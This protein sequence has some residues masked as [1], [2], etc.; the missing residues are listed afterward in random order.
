MK[1]IIFRTLIS[2]FFII[3]ASVIYLSTIGIKTNKLNDQISN[4]IKNINENLDVELKDISILIDPFRF[5]INLKSLGVNLNYKNKFIEL[6]SIQSE[7]SI[8][9]VFKNQFILTDLDISTKSVEIKKMISFLRAITNNPKLY[10][11]EKFVKRGFLIAD[12]SL[13]FDNNGN[14]KKNY[15]IKGFVKEGKINFLKRY[16]FSQIDFTFEFFK[17]EL[18]LDD[19]KLSLND[20]KFFLSGVKVTKDTNKFLFSGNLDNKLIKID[21]KE[22]QELFGSNIS[23]YGFDEIN[24]KSKNQF[25]FE[26]TNKFKIRNLKINSNIKLDNFIFSRN[27]NLDKIFPQLEDKI[28]FTNHEINVIY[29]RKNL[30]INGS[31]NILISNKDRIKYSIIK[32]DKKI[33]FQTT[34][35]I[36]E[37]LVELDFLN[38]Q[39]KENS[40]L[41]ININ[42]YKNIKG[43]YFF[44]KIILSEKDNKIFIQN[45]S[46]TK[47]FAI[48]KF[49]KVDLDYLDDENLRNKIS[50]VQNNKDYIIRGDIFNANKLIDN[51]LETKNKKQ[52]K[53]PIKESVKIDIKI[54]ET[55]LDKLNV[56]YDLGG[57]IILDN[58]DVVEAN[59]E[60]KFSNNKNIK[61]TVQT[62]Q[63]QKITTLFSS[64]AKPLV[65]RYKF[66]KGF[67]EGSLDF[68]SVKNDNETES[69]LKIYDFKLK[70]LPALTKLLTLASLQ[71]IADLLSG[72]GIRF[73]EFEMN[74]S[75]SNQSMKIDEI[76]AIGP[77]ISILMSGYIELGK[78]VSLRGTLVPA[79]TLN[80]TI[81]SI[82]ILGDILVGKKTGE[83]VFGVSFKI[84]GPPKKLETSVNPIKTLTPR[85]ITRTLEK[86][87]KN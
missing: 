32:K 3:S 83:G 20:K 29:D 22:I 64:K 39:K 49:K 66:I 47:D 55:Y 44:E 85:F 70:E 78:L 60:S 80:K 67:N 59:L 63:N 40:N 36:F 23:E 37:N 7:I 26:I 84:K 81:G 52:N 9:S 54:K 42:G 71:G 51:L 18:K 46:M 14:I 79:T 65:K 69:T 58:N 11:A 17:D 13:E 77:A 87:K 50:I 21:E 1:K 24:F 41:E 62:K 74:F 75:N 68:Y 61:F 35:K 30:K 2:I 10:I 86:I 34:I 56:I 73:N 8:K 25:S 38:Y 4:K 45:I 12:I 76:Y 16:D 31:G 48:R 53:Y 15:E 33:N 6:E 5:K 72:E 19:F 43:N 28:T 82:P 57:Y 27:L